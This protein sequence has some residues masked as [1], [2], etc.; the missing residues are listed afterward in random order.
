MCLENLAS[1]TFGRLQLIAIVQ[2]ALSAILSSVV[3]TV[4]IGGRVEV[5]SLIAYHPSFHSE[6]TI[7]LPLLPSS[8][9]RGLW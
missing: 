5:D 3:A 7:M 4:G 8:L 9:P 6:H 2:L 1:Y